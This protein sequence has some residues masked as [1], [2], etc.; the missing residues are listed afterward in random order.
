MRRASSLGTDDAE[1]GLFDD[2]EGEGEDG[3]GEDE[4]RAF[5]AHMARWAAVR[6][7][8]EFGARVWEP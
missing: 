3:E 2:G 4:I 5:A 8:R 7:S 1:R 6:E